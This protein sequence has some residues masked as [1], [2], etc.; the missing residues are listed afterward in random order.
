MFYVGSLYMKAI[1][2][3]VDEQLLK[4]LDS[5]AEARRDGRSAVIR[6]ALTEYLARRRSADIDQRIRRGYRKH[7]VDA[8][9]KGWTEEAV[10]P[11]D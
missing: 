7:P 2:V 1:Q 10:W 6:R 11:A 3:T 4:A 9:L 5:N 8:E